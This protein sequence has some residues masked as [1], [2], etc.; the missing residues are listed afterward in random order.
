MTARLIIDGVFTTYDRVD[1]LDDITLEVAP[2]RITCILGSNGA[3]KTTLIR[4]ILRLTPPHRGSISFDG[5]KLDGMQTHDVVSL[6]I[7]CIPEGRRIFS[8]MT[9]EENLRLGAYRVSSEREI[10]RRLDGVHAVFPRL[11][12]RARQLAGTMSGGEQAMVSIG[13]GLM[14]DPKLLVIDEPSLGL[15]PLFVQENFNV[16]ARINAT[17]VTVLL[18]EQNVNQTLAIAHYGYVLSGGRI[19]AQGSSATLRDDPELQRA[20]FGAMH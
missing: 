6:G 9:V 19:L 11:A 4:S 10:R 1:V 17:G 5:R 13:R 8:K 7:G 3:G 18:V 12:E 14:T 20:Y 15:S 16:I 2:G